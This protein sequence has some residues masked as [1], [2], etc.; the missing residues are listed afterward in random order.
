MTRAAIY[1]RF[2]TQLQSDRSIEDQVTLCRVF[3][4]RE[5]YEVV[6][7]YSDAAKSGAS[8]HNRDGVRNLMADAMLGAFDVVIVEALDRLSRDMEDLAGISKRLQFAGID[9]IGVH[10]GKANTVTVGLRGIVGQ[11]YREDNAHK[12]RRGLLGRVKQGLSG[13]GQAYGYRPDPLNKGKLIIVEDESAIVRRIFEE[14]AGGASPRNIAHKLNLDKV[15]PPRGLKW[16]ASTINGSAQRGN[17]IL[18]NQLYA[19][20]IVWNKVRMI[21]DPD[22]GRRLSRP[23]PESEWEVNEVPELR[24]VP[25]ELW[26]LAQGRRLARPSP[27][28]AGRMR[29]PKRLLSGLLKCGCC[30]S[31]MT[32][33]GKD[34]SGR[35]RIRC[36]ADAESGSCPDPKT[37]YL[38]TVEKLVIG[39]LI[40]HLRAPEGLGLFIRTYQEEQARLAAART[41]NKA[42]FEQDLTRVRK[43]ISSLAIQIADDLVQVEDVRGELAD[44]R[45][46]KQKLEAELAAAPEAPKVV[47]LMPAAIQRFE[48]S[49][50]NLHAAFKTGFID[51]NSEDAAFMREVVASIT[52]FRKEGRKKGDG[53]A[54]VEIELVGHLNA[55]LVEQPFEKYSVLSACNGP[56]LPFLTT[57]RSA[58]FSKGFSTSRALRWPTASISTPALCSAFLPPGRR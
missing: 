57:P 15:A 40:G 50:S 21:K 18:H 19:G 2:S 3:A 8:M 58:L 55:L 4:Q 16:N 27:A 31:G 47:T 35:V 37:F 28:E 29:R 32:T 17:G 43:R 5:G 42:K 51:A 9:L 23:N 24:L 39:S 26:V 34:S 56:P 11:L 20:K 1:A 53:G 14:Y 25:D 52:V 6:H 12:V 44:L 38:D 45:V 48:R 54:G 10:D 46:E 41:S 33:M 13:G 36:S 22:T 30:G 49:M 7:V